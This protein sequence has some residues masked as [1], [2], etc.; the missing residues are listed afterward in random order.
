MEQKSIASERKISFN[1]IE[2]R[3]KNVFSDFVLF[4]WLTN[5]WKKE[6]RNSK[7]KNH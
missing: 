2:K 5:W 7:Y 3:A 1:W 4:D 6:E